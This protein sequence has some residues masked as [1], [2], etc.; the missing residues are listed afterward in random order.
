MALQLQKGQV[1]NKT[2][3]LETIDLSTLNTV[4]GGLFGLGLS[5]A[6]VGTVLSNGAVVEGHLSNGST[7]TQGAPPSKFINLGL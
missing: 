1:M 6:P 2:N 4:S 3:Q 7:I 5:H